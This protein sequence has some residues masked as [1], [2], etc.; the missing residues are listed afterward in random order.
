MDAVRELSPVDSSSLAKR[1]AARIGPMV[2][3]LDGPM[4][5]L[6]SS[7]RLCFTASS[8]RV[9]LSLIAFY[10]VLAGS[11]VAAGI[12]GRH[13]SKS[14]LPFLLL[15]RLRCLAPYTGLL[16]LGFVS[17]ATAAPAQETS[18][19]I[20]LDVDATTISR[21]ILST[22]ES[23]PVTSP[24]AH[25][26]DLVYP[27]WIPGDH[28]PTGPIADLVNLRFTADGKTLAWVRDPVDM[29]RFHIP[30]PAGTN[31]L[32]ADFSLVGEYVAGN[33]FAPGNTSTPVQGDVNWDQVILYPADTVADQ[34]T[35]S[36]SIKL[37]DQWSYATA[38][39]NP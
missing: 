1:S 9:S 32:V 17:S 35:V 27:K 33:D 25:T 38:L 29:Y 5:I 26:V 14:E 39:P 31:L 18:S 15:H 10:S 13:R 23:F 20:V 6:N 34:V 36:P 24:L 4:P 7:K 37:P 22:H 2:C 28:A 19:T 8:W 12:R 11:R 30:V 3:E 16:W 21:K